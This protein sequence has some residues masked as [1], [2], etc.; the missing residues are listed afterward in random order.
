MPRGCAGL[1][2]GIDL[3][4]LPLPDQVAH[5][6]V[7]NQDL[8][9]SH[10]ATAVGRRHQSLRDD[11][12]ER[13]GELHAH[14]VLL[15]GGEHVDD[16]VDR[17][18]R[19]LGVQ[20]REHEVPR[21]GRGQCRADRLE[22]AHLADEDHV[23]VLAQRCAQRLGERRCVATDL[24]LVD[25]AISVPVQELDRIL[26]REDVLAARAVDQVEHCCQRRR[27]T[28]AGR[29]GDEHQAARLGGE[30]GELSG[31]PQL[32]E[33]LD[34]ARDHAEGST[35]R[36][37]LEEGVDAEAS[38]TRQRVRQVDVALRLERLLLLG[39]EDAVDELA[40]DVG[41]QLLEFLEPLKPATDADDGLCA[42]RHVEVGGLQFLCAAEQIVDR[43]L[44]DGGHVASPIGRVVTDLRGIQDP[45]G[46]WHAPPG[47]IGVSSASPRPP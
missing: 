1:H 10:A 32:G 43:V 39:G 2:S 9:R 36:L 24:A 45:V 33:R 22:I 29:A 4:D 27:L 14:L 40:G 21:L 8:E 11:T 42:G 23:R 28:R 26:D 31:Q 41:R 15:L 19:T 44:G 38:D 46:E 47:R 7:R 20:G 34:V 12:L 30:I 16:A 18:G 5:G 35:D 17:L 25:D 6:V 37:A 3:L 13:A